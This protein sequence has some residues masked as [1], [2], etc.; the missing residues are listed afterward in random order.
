MTTAPLPDLGDPPLFNGCSADDLKRARSLLT[1]IQLRAGRVLMRTG[2]LGRD[3]AI[4]AEGNVEVTSPLGER[5]AILGPGD[6]VGEVALLGGKV[7]NATVTALTP[8]EVF[9]GSSKEFRSLL[10]QLPVVRD[11]IVSTAASR[12]AA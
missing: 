6:V 11:R 7:R 5:L 8:I 3:F 9:V 10:D 4:I 2:D 1:P 12:L